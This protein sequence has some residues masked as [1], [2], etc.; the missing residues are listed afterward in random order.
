M[1]VTIACIN[2]RTTTYL[3][4]LTKSKEY[5]FVYYEKRVCKCR[6][7]PAF[8]L[9]KGT[10]NALLIFFFV[11]CAGYWSTDL[12]DNARSESLFRKA[13]LQA[14][15]C[16]RS[17]NN[18][19]RSQRHFEIVTAAERADVVARDHLSK[20]NIRMKRGLQWKTVNALRRAPRRC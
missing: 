16:F 14:V 1:V 8:R 18:V 6:N 20:A 17:G 19:R 5:C 15:A 10:F 7:R 13:L 11:H 12:Q 4:V 2:S 3:E 9:I